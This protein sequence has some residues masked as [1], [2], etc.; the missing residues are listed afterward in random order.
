M[1]Q[2]V[3][4]RLKTV[5]M[6]VVNGFNVSKSRLIQSNMKTRCAALYYVQAL[7]IIALYRSKKQ[8]GGDRIPSAIQRVSGQARK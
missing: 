5:E 3:K 4:E 2:R 7:R 8:I 6:S 1:S